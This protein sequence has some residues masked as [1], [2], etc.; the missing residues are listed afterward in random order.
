MI[1]YFISSFTSDRDI[2]GTNATEE[3]NGTCSVRNGN[4][5]ESSKKQWSLLAVLVICKLKSACACDLL[6]LHTAALDS[7]ELV[8]IW[9]LNIDTVLGLAR[10]KAEKELNRSVI[11]SHVLSLN[12]RKN[13]YTM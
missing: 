1:V 9:E 3:P 6:D 4:H 8:L 11:T 7:V 10:E 12:S 5:S 2:L 13:I